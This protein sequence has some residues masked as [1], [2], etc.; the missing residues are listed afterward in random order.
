MNVQLKKFNPRS[1]TTDSIMVMI[2]RRG[3]GKS[4]LVQDIMYYV[5]RIPVFVAVSGT[6]EGNSFFKDHIPDVLIYNEFDPAL[7]KNLIRRQKKLIKQHPKKKGFKK[8]SKNVEPTDLGIVFDD[9]MFD[10]KWT[11][12]EYIRWIF[13][14]GR[15]FNICFIMTMQYLMDLPPGLRAQIDYVFVTKESKEVNKKRLYDQFFGVFP[16]KDSFYQV[17]DQCTE[18][19]QCLV[20]NNKS[21]SNKIEDCVFWY[22]A[23]PDRQFKTCSKS[24]WSHCKKIYNPDYDDENDENMLPTKTK[25]NSSKNSNNL[26]NNLNNNINNLNKLHS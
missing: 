15:H 1:I 22:K 10:K 2:G 4:T 9:L 11:K 23:T 3:Q 7:I 18:N 8:G 19:Y 16:T 6:E 13:M 20:L 12:D 5:R 25:N 26:N 17:L 24:L 14:N 21:I